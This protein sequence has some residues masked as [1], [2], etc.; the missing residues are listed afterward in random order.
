M[1]LKNLKLIN[2]K[3]FE[4]KE[5][6][7]SSKINC[8]VGQN[9][10]GKTNTLDAIH[11]LSL[12]KSYLQ[13]SDLLNIKFD[14]EFFVIEGN[15]VSNE[16]E[17]IIR[18]SVKKEQKKV[19]KKNNKA[20]E[21]ITD[22]I[23]KYATVVISPYDRDLITEGSEFRRKFLDG[24]LS[25]LNPEYLHTLIRYNKIVLQRNTL[26][27][28]FSNNHTFNVENLEIYNKEFIENAAYIHKKRHDFLALFSP[29]LLHY[30]NKISPNKEQ[31]NLEYHSQL[32]HDSME[33]LLKN[34]V[35][36]DRQSTY[37]NAGIHKDDLR[38]NI[39]E[40]PIKKF[41]SQGQQKT[42]LIALKLAQMSIFKEISGINPI[43]LL[44]DIFD[45]LDE[46]RVS[47][48]IHLVNEE[49]FGQIF[50]TDTHTKRTEDIV[51]QIDENS[52]IFEL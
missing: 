51:K 36:K 26:L 45:K 5:F 52:L 28:Y 50:I 6:Q 4:E 49:H 47:Q 42:F 14:E 33:N 27:K 32:N 35:E 29:K 30:Y 11:Y 44:D 19:I 9:G 37:T 8:I 16:S 13:F 12:T 18:I 7:F 38:F 46:T 39:N 41:G 25:Q 15:F 23:G 22:H 1:Y 17:D 21:K 40:N 43:L 48:L 10:M 2:F 20:Y 3:N 31:V 34:N 24:M